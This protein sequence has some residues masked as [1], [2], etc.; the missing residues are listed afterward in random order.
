MAQMKMRDVYN[1]VIYMR[2][3]NLYYVPRTEY[4]QAYTAVFPKAKAIE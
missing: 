4:E 2:S 3:G 1:C